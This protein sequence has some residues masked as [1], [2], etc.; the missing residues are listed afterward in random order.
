MAC[1]PRPAWQRR[2][3]AQIRGDSSWLARSQ[4]LIANVLQNV[5]CAFHSH[6]ARKNWVFILHAEHSLISDLHICPHDLFPGARTVAVAYSAEGF[7]SQRQ[8]LSFE[9]E[10]EHS[11]TV[12]VLF[13]KSRVLHVGMKNRA[14]LPQHVNNFN[15]VALL[16]EKM[17]E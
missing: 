5:E 9:R 8:I 1:L 12:D 14:L 13:V 7:R 3:F 10:I 17:A 2:Q 11:V 15:G 6:F 4:Q 16:P